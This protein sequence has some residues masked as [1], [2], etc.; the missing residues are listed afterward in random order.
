MARLSVVII[1]Y[2]AC[3]LLAICGGAIFIGRSL[4]SEPAELCPFCEKPMK[5][6]QL[7]VML[8]DRDTFAHRECLRAKNANGGVLI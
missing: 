3:A 6:G 8:D 1:V 5:Q 7:R 4:R 2:A